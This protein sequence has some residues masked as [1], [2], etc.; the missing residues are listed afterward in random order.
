MVLLH[1]AARV[2]ARE[3]RGQASLMMLALVA[4][5]LFGA[6][7]LFGF[8][9]ALGAKGR[10]QRAADLA[11]VS[12]AQVM[13]ELY[14]RL[15]EPPFIEPDVPNPRHLEEAEYSALAVAA[16]VRGARRNGVRLR[17]SDVSFGRT[18]FAPT[19]VTVRVRGEARVRFGPGR[20][21]AGRVPVRASATAELTPDG[22]AGGLP[23]HASGGGYDGPLA[24][25]QGKPM[26]PDV[27]L[28]FDRMAAAARREAGI[29]LGVTSGFRSD[30]EQARLFAAHP[31]PKWVA[32]PG[33]SLHRYA[34]ELDLG[35]REAYAWLAANATRF[36][37]LQ[38]YGWEPWHYG[39]PLA[40]KSL[41]RCVGA[42]RHGGV[43]MRRTSTSATPPA[44]PLDA[45]AAERRRE[46]PSHG[47][48]AHSVRASARRIGCCVSREAGAGRGFLLIISRRAKSLRR[49]RGRPSSGA[50]SCHPRRPTRSA[51]D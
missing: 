24:Y 16:A 26:R 46:Y 41:A 39:L 13:R 51:R 45:E 47:E 8:G 18:G 4:G 21:A 5:L 19:R 7:V 3:E 23:T 15:F 44:S 2:F 12:A 32:P 50:P 42:E 36:G 31:D 9:N 30:A 49:L 35:P 29:L 34:T 38:R 40:H 48:G 33:E 10:H 37:F 25:R 27:A 11:A 43:A 14:P 20:R 1:G 6:L 22:G 28:A 17:A